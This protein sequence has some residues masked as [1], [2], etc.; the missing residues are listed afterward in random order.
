M[1]HPTTKTPGT[2]WAV[3][4][5]ASSGLG[6]ESALALVERG[7]PL[8]AVARRGERLRALADEVGA[9]GGRLEPLVADLPTAAGV[10]ALLAR[11]ASPELAML[12]YNAGVAT[13]RP[14]EHDREVHAVERLSGSRPWR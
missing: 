11:S 9:R 2:G 7:H 5:G 6:R 12:V 8:L 13:P 1:K 10:E 3:V 4:T 14:L